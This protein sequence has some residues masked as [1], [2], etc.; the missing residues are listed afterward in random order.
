MA[1]RKGKLRGRDFG[2]GRWADLFRASPSDDGDII[3]QGYLIA[4]PRHAREIANY[5][6]AL[7]DQQESKEV[8][9]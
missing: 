7:C 1:K 5:I 2:S 6:L 8:T 9:R 4:T 3:V